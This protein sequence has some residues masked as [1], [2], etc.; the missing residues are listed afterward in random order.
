M[1]HCCA[2]ISESFSPK[3]RLVAPF[4]VRELF[5]LAELTAIKSFFAFRTLE[6]F[7]VPFLAVKNGFLIEIDP[8]A[9][10]GTSLSE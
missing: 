8:L 2:T 7:L 4:A 9:A 6:A 1:Q 5:M 10:L 3:K